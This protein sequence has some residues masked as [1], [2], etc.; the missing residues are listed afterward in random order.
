MFAS[1]V[2]RK[3]ILIVNVSNDDDDLM[4]HF[5]FIFFFVFQYFLRHID[6][7]RL[8]FDFFFY[9]ICFVDESNLNRFDFLKFEN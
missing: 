7:Y 6:V 8:N 1:F 4:I 2:K 9:N 5:F 3:N